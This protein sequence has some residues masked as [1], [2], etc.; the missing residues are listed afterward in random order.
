[1]EVM[2]LHKIKEQI[3]KMQSEENNIPKNVKWKKKIK[4]C[5][6]LVLMAVVFL[7]VDNLRGN[8]RKYQTLERYQKAGGNVL[9]EIPVNAGDCRFAIFRT[10][11]SKCY[12]YSF[13]LDK[14]SFEKYVIELAEQHHVNKSGLGYDEWYGKKVE[15]CYDSKYTFDNFPTRLTFTSVID[16]PIEDYE[17]VIYRPHGTGTHS[18]GVVIN[19]N[20]YR[21]VV[22]ELL[23]L[24]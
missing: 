24:R 8:T 11:I 4:L 17:V 15:D 19:R 20:T 7:F 5:I 3:G 14:D 18:Y 22:Y 6:I 21:V 23:T 2:F 9:Y 12:F 13:E 16:D 10:I 1:M